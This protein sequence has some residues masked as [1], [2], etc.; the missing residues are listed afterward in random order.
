MILAGEPSGDVH[1]SALVKEIKKI[2][3]DAKISGMGGMN[4][5][6]AGVDLFYP[7]DR[8]S[9]MGLTEVLLQMKYIKQAFNEFKAQLKKNKPDLLI[10]IDYPGFNLRAAKFAK[11]HFQIK[12][13]YYITPKVWAW[14]SGRLYRMKSILDHAAL[15]FP[16]EERLYKKAGIPATYVGNPLVD[17]IVETRTPS[18]GFPA[19]AD[20]SRSSNPDKDLTIGILPGSRKAE[21]DNLLEIMLLAG[22]LIHQQYK[23]TRFLVSCADSVSPEKIRNMVKF[24]NSGNIFEIVTGHPRKIFQKADLLIAASG[25]VTLEAAL[26]RVPTIL[27]YKM[28][29]VSYR[30]AKILVKVKYA[31]LANIIMGREVMPELLQQDATPLNI[32]AK[33]KDMLK[34]LPEYARA[35]GGVKKL[36]GPPGASKRAAQ[37][38]VTI[39]RGL[40]S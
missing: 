30:L 8:L 34:D 23:N 18:P 36:L 1:A 16:F 33:A 35:L 17:D 31:G 12:I 38:A 22:G 15:I 21:V 14:N 37:M 24:H 28:S 3:P 32:Y 9:A 20:R 26:Y 6:S 5:M 27:I 19:L 7:I 13:I 25:T 40:R 11:E 4:M 29:F 10:L 39:A 2:E